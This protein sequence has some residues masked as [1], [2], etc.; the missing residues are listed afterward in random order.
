MCPCQTIGQFGICLRK[1]VGDPI[2]IPNNI[3]FVG[4]DLAGQTKGEQKKKSGL[5][6][7]I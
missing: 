1:Y 7:N 6:Q 4:I 5:F 2:G 3:N